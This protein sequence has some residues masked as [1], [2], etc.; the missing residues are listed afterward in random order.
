M[1]INKQL[2]DTNEKI[3]IYFEKLYEIKNILQ[4]IINIKQEEAEETEDKVIYLIEMI[5]KDIEIFNLKHMQI[6]KQ[7]EKNNKELKKEIEFLQQD[8]QHLKK[9]NENI[10]ETERKKYIKMVSMFND[11]ENKITENEEVI[12]NLNSIIKNL[13]SIIQKTDDI[14]KENYQLNTKLK[15]YYDDLYKINNLLKDFSVRKTEI[16][17]IKKNIKMII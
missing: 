9:Q 5:K 10:E 15:Y 4:N 8:N 12:K 13:N 16:E 2:K 14:K 17:D 7:Y 6:I 11:F 1:E 3:N